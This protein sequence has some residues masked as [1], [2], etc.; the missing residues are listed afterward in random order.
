MRV[1]DRLPL[2]QKLIIIITSIS[3]TALLIAC[4]LVISYDVHRFRVN[5]V[6]QLILLAD[7]VGQNSAAAMAFNDR[8]A[9]SEILASSR[10]ASSVFGVCLY[11]SDGDRFSSYTRDNSWSCAESPPRDGLLSSWGELTLVRPVIVHRERAGTVVVHCHLRE[12]NPRLL[13]YAAIIFCV[14]LNSSVVAFFLATRL[15]RV[16]TRPI[17]RLLKIARTVSRTGDYS[18]RAEAETE[19]EIGQLVSGFND[20]LTEVQTRDRKLEE[21]QQSLQEE[22]ARQTA[23]LRL[24]NTDLRQAKEAAESASRAKSEFLANMSHEIRT[25]LNGVIGM[26]ELALDSDLDPEQRECLLTAKSSGD[27]LLK[28]I[29]DILD[30]SKIEAGKLELE[31]IEYDLHELVYDV[32]KPMAVLAQQKDLEILCE[33]SPDVPHRVRGDS[34]RLRQVLQNL[35]SNALKFT[36]AGEVVISV[37]ASDVKADEQELRFRVADT[38]I[39]IPADKQSAIFHPFSQADSSTTRR[40]GG[41]GL[42][43]TII[44][45]LLTMMGGRIWLKSEVG[46]G[47]EFFFTVRVGKIESVAHVERPSELP[48]VRV[49]VVDDNPTNRRIVQEL[50]NGWGMIC[51]AADSAKSAMRLLQQANEAGSPYRLAILDQHMP[52]VDGFELATMMRKDAALSTTVRMMLTSSDHPGDIARCRELGIERYLLKPVVSSELRRTL[53]QMLSQSRVRRDAQLARVI[54]VSGSPLNILIVEDNPVNQTFLQRVLIRMGHKAITAVNGVEAVNCYKARGVD[55]IFMDVQMP[56]M[57]GYSA[58]ATIRKLESGSAKHVPIIAMTA[59]ALKGDREKCLA[60]GMDDYLGKPAKIAE[61]QEAIERIAGMREVQTSTGQQTRAASGNAPMWDRTAALNR[62]GGDEL[63]LNDLIEVFFED[64][65]AI[66]A[67]MSDSLQ[68]GDISSLR[69]PAHT[70][71]GSLGHLGLTQTAR[72]AEKIELASKE[73]DPAVLGLINGFMAQ[74]ESLQDIMLPGGATAG[75]AND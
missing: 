55:L 48:Q 72:L 59:H 47:S 53:E 38:G 15:Q 68:R 22:V 64:Y 30:F 27:S 20:M 5:Q 9:A 8:Q 65:P 46:K 19:D 71:K 75:V 66:A 50:C 33:L 14:L 57:D 39:G 35:L 4:L 28:V 67:R 49:L 13:R 24:L 40:Y 45:R 31:E 69:E 32:I 62:L 54:Q 56:E 6:E 61:I 3:G 58:T 74:I 34:T 18:L 37:N 63:L 41:T 60:S 42:G 11:L 10:F 25:P 70:L 2:G 52:E 29:N 26:L 16:V 51:D 1:L 7:V 73:D 36:A 21:S 44:S 43:L 23:D 12:L 17:R